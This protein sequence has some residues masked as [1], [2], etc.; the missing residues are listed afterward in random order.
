MRQP[1]MLSVLGDILEQFAK[2]RDIRL[3]RDQIE[4]PFIIS[5]ARTLNEGLRIRS[6]YAESKRD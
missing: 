5:K 1:G 6:G 2:L 4:L 3:V